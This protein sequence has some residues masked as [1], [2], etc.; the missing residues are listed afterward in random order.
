MAIVSA[1]MFHGAISRDADFHILS[2]LEEKDLGQAEQVCKGWKV[3]AGNDRLW[4]NL[5][6]RMY[7]KAV[8]KTKSGKEACLSKRRTKTIPGG[9]LLD[10]LSRFLCLLK[11]ETKR[12]LEC[13]FLN[14][15]T[16]SLVIEQGFGPHRGTPEG[17]EGPVNETEYYEFVGP[18]F[19]G[20]PANQTWTVS[21]EDRLGHLPIHTTML[22]TIYHQEIL[23][24][25]PE[26]DYIPVEI[27]GVDVGYGNTLAY[28]SDTDD[29]KQPF[30]LTC[31]GE[32]TWAGRI[33][34]SA[35]KF[36][37]IDQ[38]GKVTWEKGIPTLDTDT[39]NRY[40]GDFSSHFNSFEEHLT[41]FPVKF[42]E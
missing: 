6:E 28:F 32:S 25:M 4:R 41:T 23:K 36:V 8:P 21:R 1:S 24:N 13:T 5:F 12:R 18:T 16:F 2:F 40:W 17:F 33:P 7:N 10:T 14:D 31:I 19:S 15:P 27:K 35:F 29:W 37:K 9:K 38:K 11:W 30:P 34:Y 20:Q 42:Q 39:G 22:W 26:W 3:L